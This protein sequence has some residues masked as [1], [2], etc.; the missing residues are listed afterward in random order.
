MENKLDIN[1]PETKK[2]L[3]KYFLFGLIVAISTRYIPTNSIN[4]KEILMI[5]AI[6]SIS[7]GIIDMVSPSIKVN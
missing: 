3:L 1:N 6:A 2:K 5:S 4:N 7:F